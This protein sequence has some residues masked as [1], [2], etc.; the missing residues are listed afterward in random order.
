MLILR[1]DELL[2][3]VDPSHG[4][5]VLDLVELGSGRQLLGRPPF[6]SEAPA[7]GDLDE[8]PWTAAWRGGWQGCLPNAGT[9]CEVDAIRHGFHGRA[10]ND[11]WVVVEAGERDCGVRW[12][13]HGLAAER[14]MEVSNALTITTEVTALDQGAPLVALEHLS[15]GLELIEP[16]VELELPAGPASELDDSLGPATPAEDAPRWPE[17]ALAGGG[18]ERG[19]RWA[20]EEQRGRVYVVRD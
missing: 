4:A 14:R 15:L 12:E 5:E 3:R 13:G 11:P 1:S 6:G 20:L 19:E 2:V 17:I 9:A 10:S 16:R 8:D 7:P 18:T